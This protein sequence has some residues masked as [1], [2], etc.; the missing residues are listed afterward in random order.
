MAQ[1]DADALASTM[2]GNIAALTAS[3]AENATEVA[4]ATTDLTKSILTEGSMTRFNLANVERDL[5]NRIHEAR[6]EA[7]KTNTEL[8]RYLADKS[9]GIKERLTGFERNV[10]MNF[11]DVLIDAEK[12]AAAITLNAEKNA[13]A[14]ALAGERNTRIITDKLDA[15]ERR[16]L[17]DELDETRLDN[18]WNRFNSNVNS[19]FAL[20]NQEIASL[21]NMI[22]SVEQTQ[23][24]SSKTVQFGAGNV[25]IPTQTANQG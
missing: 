3:V 2:M 11:R 19:N 10:D 4:E 17:K 7:L 20:Q 1:G 23:R 5:Q 6:V 22:N 8:S 12:N 24:F 21:K 9:D 15:I 13:A 25:A 18:L 16:S 14:I